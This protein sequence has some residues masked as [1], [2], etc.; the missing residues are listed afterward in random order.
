[1]QFP[2]AGR[3]WD[4][5]SSL[6]HRFAFHVLCASLRTAAGDGCPAPID[7]L[8]ELL[9]R[10]VFLMAFPGPVSTSR[11]GKKA[12]DSWGEAERRAHAEAGSKRWPRSCRKEA[13]ALLSAVM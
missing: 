5:W 12:L 4:S 1:M 2:W 10:S 11:A 8:R 3:R 6:R 9:M 13:N 7:F